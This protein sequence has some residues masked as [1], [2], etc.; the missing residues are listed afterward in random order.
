MNIQQIIDKINEGHLFVPAFQREYVWKRPHVKA[1]FDSLIKKYPTGTL[2]TWET[3]NPPEVKGRKEYNP[4]MGAVKLILDGQQR[5]TSLY[6]IMTGEIPPY[7]TL[8][9]IKHDIRNLYVN[10]LTLEL[11]YYKPKTMGKSPLWVS[12]TDIFTN[13][14]KAR[15]V[16]KALSETS[17]VDD[18]T[19][20]KIHD[21]FDA[22]KSIQD[23]EFVEQSIPV[24]AIIRDAIDIF[25]IV[26]ASGVNLTDAELALAQI[27]GYWPEARKLFKK[28]LDE[29]TN[30][31]F[32][33]KLDF[34]VYVILGVLHNVGSEMKRLH[35]PEN[36]DPL[37]AAWK[38]LDEYVLD[39]VMN[40]MQ[41]HAYIDHSSEINSV[42][43]LV[44]II[45]YVYQ[46]EDDKL[47]QLEI[48]KAVKW[49]YY[50]QIRHRYVSQLPQKLDKDLR[51]IKTSP[52]PFD[53]LLVNIQAERPLEISKDEFVGR[54]VR[55]PLF[56]LMR[57]YFK[58]KNAIC[59][60]TGVGLR[61]NMGR[62]YQLE[63]DHIFA[64]S[65]L[66]DYGFNMNNRHKYALAQEITNRAI[67]TQV[68]NRDKSTQLAENY[69]IEVKANFPNALKLQCI[70]EDEILWKVENY[71]QFLEERRKIL[72]YE[73]NDYLTNITE[74]KLEG[75]SVSLEERIEEG[76]NNCLEFKS[77]LRWDMNE[78]KLNKKLE[79]VIMKSIA[80]FSNAEG[81]TLLIGVNDEGEILGLEYDYS[82]LN[83]GEGDK[84]SFEIHLRNLINKTYGVEFATNNLIITFPQIDD[85]EICIIDIKK[86]FRHLYT[87]VTDKHGQKLEKF[88]VR[89]GNSSQEISK[90]SE[91]TSYIQSRFD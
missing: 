27:S 75:V 84:D 35:S 18:E 89:S 53:D 38:R 36:L 50:S 43:A 31:G 22:I 4:Q 11:E 68:E 76:E 47:S 48:K 34:M 55:H 85:Q 67:L 30:K 91:I 2:L 58:S 63:K 17:E 32:V 70:P 25:Y 79:D 71:E 16:V 77:S 14:V 37:K 21:H 66:R 57:W 26:N 33:F 20:D 29:L 8:K 62:K 1:F 54:D 9:D 61:Q 10:L 28:K 90:A 15:H 3:A 81:G 12:L 52:N 59:L 46:K 24:T 7:Y 82:T 69:L 40:I 42:Y 56:S 87:T 49:F 74:T 39:Y 65:V 80:A 83:D 78:S 6:M 73:L 23:R 51:I 5:I 88:Y 41:S 72:A 44:P 86:G 13:S 64:Y 60:G 19:E 45:S